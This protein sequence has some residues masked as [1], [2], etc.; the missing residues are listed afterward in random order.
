MARVIFFPGFLLEALSICAFVHRVADEPFN[1]LGHL[2]VRLGS[3]YDRDRRKDAKLGDRVY[4]AECDK[5]VN[6]VLR[7]NGN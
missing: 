7:A 5:R 6:L 1:K 3:Q 4:W 2:V